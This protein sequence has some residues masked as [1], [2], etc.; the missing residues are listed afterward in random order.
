VKDSRP[1]GEEKALDVMQ[2]RVHAWWTAVLAGQADQSH[3]VHGTDVKARV[4]GNTLVISGH[5]PATSRP[6]PTATRSSARPTT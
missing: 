1:A 4:E 5:Y 2:D 3:P 6:R